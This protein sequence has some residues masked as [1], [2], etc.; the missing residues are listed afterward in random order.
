[1]KKQIDKYLFLAI[2]ICFLFIRCRPEP[3]DIDLPQAEQK[4]VIA[5]QI[6]PGNL[7]TVIVSKSMDTKG[8]NIEDGS[9]SQDILSQL[10][11][12]SGIVTINYNGITDTL[13]KA[14]GVPG[15][16]VS[17]GTPLLVNTRYNLF[18]KDW[19]TGMSVTS[20]AYMLPQVLLDTVFA[21][22]IKSNELSQTKISYSFYDPPTEKNWYMINFYSPNGSSSSSGGIDLSENDDI[23]KETIIV[24][25]ENFQNHLVNK[26]YTLSD[27]EQDTIFMSISSIS[28][29]YFDYLNT[30]LRGG[31]LFTSLVREP[32]NYPTNIHEGYGFFTTHYPTISMII[33]E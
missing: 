13:R 9:L 23:L 14:A 19:Q 5:S 30:R 32:I 18:V 31:R 20:S 25:D 15:V 2:S 28:E 29:G 11:I 17:A 26:S 3:L 16:F 12:D 33:I 24:S 8:F 7:M 27:W 6:I 10:L 1:M 4:L 21:E 22:T